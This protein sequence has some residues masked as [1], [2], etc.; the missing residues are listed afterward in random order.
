[1]LEYIYK[2]CDTIHDDV[3]DAIQ[4]DIHDDVQDDIHGYVPPTPMSTPNPD[5]DQPLYGLGVSPLYPIVS[6]WSLSSGVEEEF[7]RE[8]TSYTERGFLLTQSSPSSRDVSSIF[9]TVSSRWTSSD[10][11]LGI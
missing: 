6:S 8:D 7:E 10:E 2:V 1:M 11:S 3:Q 4:D 9:R 5:K